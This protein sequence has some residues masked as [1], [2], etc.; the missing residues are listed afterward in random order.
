MGDKKTSIWDTW[1]TPDLARNPGLANDVFRSNNPSAVAPVLSMANKGVTAQDAVNDHIE[2]NGSDAF[3]NRVGYKALSGLE[4]IGK[5]LKEIQRVY[6]FNHAVYTDHGFLQGFLVSLGITGGAVLGGVLGGGVGAA[7]GADIAGVALRKLS[8]VGPLESKYKDS[9]SKSE[10]PNYIVSPGR[11]FSNALATASDAIGADSAAKVFRDTNAGVGKIISG[12]TDLGFDVTV[13]P[14]MIVGR[15]AQLTKTGKYLGLDK[16]GEIELKYPIMGTV[17]GV[18]QFLIERSRVALTS[19]QIDAVRAGSGIFNASSRV[20]NRALDDIARST[21][22][23]IIQKY[24]TLGTAA[25]GRLGAMKTADEVHEFFKTSLFFGEAEGALAGQAMLPTRTLLRAKFGDSKVIDVLR[26]AAVAKYIVDAAGNR[27]KNPEYNPLS[28]KQRLS[29]I[30]QTFSGYMPYSVDAETAKLSLNKFRWNAPDA[31]TVIYRIAKFGMGDKAAKI[32]ATKYAEAVAA[33]DVALARSIKNQTYFET[34]KAAGLPESNALVREAWDEVNKLSIDAVSTQVYGTNAFGEA[35]GEYLTASG[36][37]T[38]ALFKHQA[39]DMF[40]IPDFLVV[41]KAMRDAGKFTKYVGKI[42]EFTAKYYTNKIF[43]PLALATMGFGLRIAA[44]EMIP[45]FARFGIINT[46]KAKL[47][48]SASKANYDLIPQETNSILGATLVALGAHMGLTPDVLKAGFP[49]FQEAKRRGLEYAAKMLPD[50][51]LELATKLVLVNN[52]HFLSEGV[53]TGHG[54]DA[55]TSYQMSQAA[56][57]Y[58]QI[59]KNSPMFRDLPEWTTYSSSDIHYVPRWATNLSRA[60]N[61]TA[62]KNIAQ[63][64]DAIAVKNLVGGKFQIEDDINKIAAHQ[65]FLDLRE[66]L[67]DKEYQRMMAAISGTYKGYDAEKKVVTRWKDAVQN[68][69]L[70]SFASDR[71]DSILGMVVG[72]DGLYH[73]MVARNIANGVSTDL[74]YLAQLTR[75]FQQSVPAAVSGPMLQPYVPSSSMIEKVVNIGFKKVI[76]PIVNGLAREPLYMLHVADAYSRL[77]PQVAAGR[78]L[79]DQALRIAQSQATYSMLPQIHN[80]ALR[81]QFSQYVRNF[82]PFYFAQEQA[83]RRAYNTLKDTSIASPLFSRGF[84]FFQLAEHAIN[85][86]AFVQEDDQGNRYVYLPLV[87][88]F[89]QAVQNGLAAFG[90]PIVG[91]LPITARG[92]LISLKTV[93]PELQMP[94]VSPIGAV[95]ANLISDFFPSMAPIVRG[96][97]GEISYDRGIVD[98]IIPATWAKTA[99]AALTPIDLTNQMANATASA[100][101]AAYYHGQVPGPDSSAM[102][103][104]AFVDRIKNNARSV[105]ILKTFLNLTSPLAPQVKQEDAGIRDE[106]WK[107]VKEKGNYADALME[108]MGR[109]GNNAVSYTVGKTTSNVPGAKYPYIQETVDFIRNNEQLFDYKSGVSTGAFYL[110]PQ[111]NAKNE[112]DRAVFTELMGMHLRQYRTPEELLK[113]FYVAA[114]DAIMS[115]EISNH[116]AIINQAEANYDSYTKQQEQQRWSAIMEKMKNLYPI[117]YADYTNGEGRINAQ[118]AYNQLQ[119]IFSR[120][121]PPTHEQAKLV[122]ALMGDFER[123]QASMNQYKSVNLTGIVVQ[124]EKDNW[125]NYLLTLRESEPRLR[126]VIDSVFRKLG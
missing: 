103:R 91:G 47:A 26:N 123:H 1:V 105:L 28:P 16:A 83:L 29:S 43:K 86:P 65:K 126:P 31:A 21:A 70:R 121:N 48:V 98:T 66:E 69:S 58:F 4:W 92:S 49:A 38:G 24:P 88:E 30:Y 25:A 40:D 107:L 45:T 117:W 99:L 17:P 32:W 78:M 37:K 80:T 106:F 73:Q 34:L 64:L 100:L 124:T 10:N 59:Q 95:S 97:I 96:T 15:F 3:W 23:E 27:I 67:I 55:S 22:G 82:L 79:D 120:P 111:D 44:S 125:E 75:D 53:T 81:N 18:K 63:D 13:D 33:G 5:P 12:T 104:Q 62:A 11:D 72:K 74:N 122:K 108:F 51:Q 35:L 50:D 90:V 19:E 39:S 6:K 114:G 84:R 89:G 119:L 57:Y 113:Q 112:S 87:G 36:L 110:I 14:I 102:D 118:T 60:A 56:H 46:M 2:G 61:D 116:I 20:Y 41:K 52:G 8:T 42:D 109:H 85:D 71:V 7:I 94:G 68:G 77:A 9:Y 93:L 115:K 76:D 101:A 54:Y